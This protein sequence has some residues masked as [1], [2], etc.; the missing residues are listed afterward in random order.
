MSEPTGTLKI[1]TPSVNT[2]T[3]GS[4]LTNKRQAEANTE[5]INSSFP[6]EGEFVLDYK[7]KHGKPYIG[8]FLGVQYLYNELKDEMD[9]VD[10]WV[11]LEIQ[12]RGL[13]GK[14][15]SY[16]EVIN[17]LSK[18]L[19]LPKTISPIQKVKNISVLLKKALE[20]QKMYSK[21]GID[22]KSLEEIYGV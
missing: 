16:R 5:I 17:D 4:E 7:E 22:L 11:V 12:R 19:K 1:I 20:T 8:E 21:M 3:T 2:E 6:S 9:T 15:D 13:N 18:K 14:K 10:D